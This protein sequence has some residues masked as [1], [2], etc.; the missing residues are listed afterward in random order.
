M[1]DDVRSQSKRGRRGKGIDHATQDGCH[2]SDIAAT[3]GCTK[4]DDANRG[5][6]YIAVAFPIQMSI[7]KSLQV[8]RPQTRDTSQSESSPVCRLCRRDCGI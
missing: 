4:E 1:F 7:H 5:I 8:V 2:V 3:V 6:E